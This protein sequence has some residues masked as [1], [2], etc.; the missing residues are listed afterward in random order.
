MTTDIIVGFPGET[1]DDFEQ[2]L[3]VC[4][5]AAYDSAFT[6]VFSP[7]PG[8]RAADMESEFVAPDVVAERFERLKT[9]IDRSALARHQARVGR[10]EEALV[11]GVSRRDAAMLT[12]RTRQGKLVHFPG[13][14]D[15]PEPGALARVTV[16]S[17]HPHHL[18]A[19]L[20]EVVARPRHRRRIPVASG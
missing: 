2:T 10:S 17:G 14:P 7:R 15:G 18:T 19:R 4:A 20:D 12:G 3:A 5:E 9:V 11:E 13:D 16:V 1:E 6:F 8:T